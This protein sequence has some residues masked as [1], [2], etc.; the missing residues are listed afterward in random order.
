MNHYFDIVGKKAVVTGGARG[1]GHA[2]AKGLLEAGT[3]VVILDVDPDIK[4]TARRLNP[5]AIGIQTDLTISVQRESGFQEAV[6]L[7][8]GLDIL[9]NNA[10]I[11]VKHDFLTYPLETWKKIVELN[12]TCAFQMMQMAGKVMKERGGGKIINISSMNA[13]FGGTN[14]PAYSATKAGILQLSK[15]AANELSMYN[16]NV[17]TI[18]PGFIETELTKHI[19]EDAAIYEEKKRRIP[20]G[21]WGVPSDLI[22]TLL[23]LA[24]P[25]SD[26]LCGTVIPVDGGYLCK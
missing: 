25:A 20:K 9:V 10:G 26:Y 15:S 19:L 16:I 11:Q 7:L 8:G 18:A 24:S 2:F 22:G 3:Q 23:F 14:C 6:Q 1:I 5:P 17:N 13:F 12:L 4:N 21:R